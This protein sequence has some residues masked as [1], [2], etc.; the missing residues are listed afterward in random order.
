MAP[1]P[2]ERPYESNPSIGARGGHPVLEI[3]GTIV[4]TA[5]LGERLQ[6]VRHAFDFEGLRD[7]F[8]AASIMFSAKR[9][10]SD[11][12]LRFGTGLVYF[13]AARKSV[14]LI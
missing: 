12:M 8:P 13:S 3:N 14:V 7:A 5:F 4:P 6:A 1:R 2:C 9:S 11:R 10:S